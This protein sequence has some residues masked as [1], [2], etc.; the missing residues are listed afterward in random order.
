MSA[1][2]P[3]CAAVLAV[4]AC[5]VRRQRRARL[6][7]AATAGADL[8][9]QPLA[10][11][12]QRA[13][14]LILKPRQPP[15][16]R[17]CKWVTRM[18]I[19]TI[20]AQHHEGGSST[21]VR[22][23]LSHTRTPAAADAHGLTVWGW[24]EPGAG[25]WV[26]CQRQMRSQETAQQPGP[27]GEVALASRPQQASASARMPAHARCS[28]SLLWQKQEQPLPRL[29]R[30]AHRLP[31]PHCTARG[32][33]HASG[34]A[35]A[36]RAT[37][38]GGAHRLDRRDLLDSSPLDREEGLESRSPRDALRDLLPPSPSRSPP[39]LFLPSPSRSRPE[40]LLV[41]S[42]NAPVSMKPDQAWTASASPLGMACTARRTCFDL[43]ANAA[44][45]GCSCAPR[46]S[47][48]PTLRRGLQSCHSSPCR[49][50]LASSSSLRHRFHWHAIQS[51]ALAQ[52]ALCTRHSWRHG[53][54]GG[55][56]EHRCFVAAARPLLVAAAHA[57]D[58]HR[59]DCLGSSPRSR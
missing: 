47:R 16:K 45:C 38:A 17:I 25:K 32:E 11:A 55:A 50:V 53:P 59:R 54:H 2:P 34:G 1:S 58:V 5:A 48:A 21:A 3:P 51:S 15:A 19:G 30:W 26:L 27:V 22:N 49:S 40:R 57:V 20:A 35:W 6:A 24:A 29:Q 28:V 10:L 4:S 39:L 46:L 43:N 42:T 31:P 14:E 37:P 52:R 36:A 41:R 13:H 18:P 44:R 8:Q 56:H 9:Q 33:G 7:C 23:L 12:R